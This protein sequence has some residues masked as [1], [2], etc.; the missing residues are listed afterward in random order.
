MAPSFRSRVFRLLLLFAAVPSIAL[1]IVGYYLASDP[2]PLPAPDT[3]GNTNELR[4]YFYELLYDDI[5]L[6]LIDQLANGT[7]QTARLDFVVSVDTAGRFNPPDLLPAE[8]RE[9]LLSGGL[10]TGKGLMAVDGQFYQYVVHPLHGPAGIIGGVIHDSTLALSLEAAHNANL[11]SESHN[12]LRATYILFLGI[13]FL[14]LILVVI[15]AAYFFSSRVSRNLAEPVAALSHASNLIAAGDFKQDVKVAASGEIGTLITNFN[16][17]AKQLDQVSLRLLQSERV[18]AWRHVARRFA[19]EL[20]NPLQPILVSL[21]RLEKQLSATD[22]W[23]QVEEPLRAAR[24]EVQ[25]LTEL[26]ER[27]S[28]LAKLPPPSITSVDLTELAK[29]TGALYRERLAPFDFDI[30]VPDEAVCVQADTGFV[31]E[32]LH[33]LLQNAIDAC[34]PDDRIELKLK[35]M[36]ETV[37]LSVRDTGAGMDLETMASARLPYFTTKSKGNGLGLAIVERSM[38]ELGGQLKVV[39]HEGTGSEVTLIFRCEDK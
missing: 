22:I 29:S 35:H 37:E 27:F 15:V 25:H 1:T 16:R 12:E 11:P 10:D 9:H 17:M 26:A 3:T 38:A 19:H 33:N 21:Y 39:S 13:L 36:P 8:V 4:D 18:A 28:T 5:R 32:A 2:P 6:S 20:K 24:E 23:G 31:R 7:S 30:D 14:C 34:R